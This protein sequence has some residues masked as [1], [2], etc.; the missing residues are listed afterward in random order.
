[1]PEIHSSAQV[2]PDAQLADNV[3]VGPFAI[4]DGPAIIGAG[5]EIGPQAWIHGSVEMGT[6]NKIGYGSVVGGDPQDL[7]FDP[8]T[9]TG[10]HLGNGNVIREYVT[11]HRA[12]AAGTHTTMGDDN[13]LMNGAHL[14]HDVI[15]GNKNILANN[16]LLAGFVEVGNAV[17]IAGAC[18]FHQFVK[19]GDYV[20]VQGLTGSS[21]DVP[22]YCILR[23]LNRLSGL[24]SIGL[25]RAGFKPEE[26]KEIKS[27]YALLFQSG[28]ALGSA[29]EE[30]GTREW[31][32]A[33]TKL[34]DAMRNPS[35]K[36]VLTREEESKD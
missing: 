35:R 10:V 11:I 14:G 12:T 29:L 5:C 23:Q 28:L 7:S 18:G 32:P 9:E 26:R 30:I 3:T 22:P 33:A 19:I 21:K 2:S 15:L 1:M 13:Y 27:A 6:D 24:N 34:I 20:M 36:G 16:V 17:V 8:A 25:R 31:G 4:I